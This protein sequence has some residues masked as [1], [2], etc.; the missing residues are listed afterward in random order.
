MCDSTN[1]LRSFGSC[2]LRSM[3]DG[4][5]NC[6]CTVGRRSSRR[7][8]CSRC[9]AAAARAEGLTDDFVHLTEL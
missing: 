6:C 3:S 9:E 8:C 5:K 1:S 4:Q 7:I 2:V